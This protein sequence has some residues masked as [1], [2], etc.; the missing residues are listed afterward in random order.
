MSIR[1]PTYC[2]LVFA[3]PMVGLAPLLE[4]RPYRTYYYRA[5]AAEIYK[6]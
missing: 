5:D 6:L 4:A 3:V 1:P 2:T